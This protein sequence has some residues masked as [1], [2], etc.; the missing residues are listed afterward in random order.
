MAD[1]RTMLT[2]MAILTMIMTVLFCLPL[3]LLDTANASKTIT[4]N[5][6]GGSLD[7]NPIGQ[8]R[9]AD[10]ELTGHDQSTYGDLGLIDVI[11]ARGTGLGWN[12]VAQ[13]TDFAAG[14]G[15]GN[16]I[17]AGGLAVEGTQTVTTLAGSAAPLAFSGPLN[18]PLT[19]LSAPAGDGMG[20]YQTTPGVSLLVPADTFTGS[21][22]STL[23]LTINST[24]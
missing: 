24:N 17:P 13:A 6:R 5:V 3:L 12:L 7:L 20:H 4:V 1:S 8:P 14:D 2:K 10:I 11:D 21:Y 22:E 15:S 19:V 16:K 18:S 9:L 23:T